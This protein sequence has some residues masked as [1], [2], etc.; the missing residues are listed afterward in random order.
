LSNPNFVRDFI[1]IEDMI[2]AYL[3][4]IK[5]IKKIKGEIF[6]LGT[7]KQTTIDEVV[8]LVKKLTHSSIEP[9]YNKVAP[10]QLEPKICAADI[11]K[12]KELLNWKPRYNLEKGLRKDIDW[13]KKNIYI[14]E[15]E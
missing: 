10:T 4:A 9:C 15:T 5:K 13:F 8:N 6:N 3:K 7:G 11:S 12:A 14:Y 2:D 1:F